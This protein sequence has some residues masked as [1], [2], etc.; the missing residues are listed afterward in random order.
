MSISSTCTACGAKCAHESR[1]AAIAAGWA[2]VEIFT[3][4]RVKYHALCPKDAELSKWLAAALYEPKKKE[5]GK[6]ER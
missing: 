6:D 1:H 2:F 4:D 5:S 3:R